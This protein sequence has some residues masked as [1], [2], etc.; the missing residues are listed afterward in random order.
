MAA[1]NRLSPQVGG[2]HVRPVVIMG[3]LLAT[4]LGL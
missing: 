3:S 4:L 2:L 1:A